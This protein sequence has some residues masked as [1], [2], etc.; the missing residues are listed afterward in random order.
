M[1]DER[2]PDQEGSDKG[3][4]SPEQPTHEATTPPGNPEVDEEALRRSEEGLERPG[5]G[6]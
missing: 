2:T 6:H 5:A 4:T 3:L 1:T